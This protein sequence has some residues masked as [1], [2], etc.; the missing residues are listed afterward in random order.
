MEATNITSIDLIKMRNGQILKDSLF[1][2]VDNDL[3]H[4]ATLSI[5]K[6]DR[7]FKVLVKSETGEVI[8]K[9]SIT[10]DVNNAYRMLT[11]LVSSIY[12]LWNE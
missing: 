1:V 3:Y 4:W 6:T 11:L 5:K 10:L 7:K 9:T 2:D 8:L 12:E